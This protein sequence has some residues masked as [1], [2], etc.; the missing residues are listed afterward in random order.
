MWFGD[1][2]TL[3]WWNDLWLNETFATY[4]SAVALERATEYQDIWK[5]FFSGTKQMAYYEDQLVTSHPISGEVKDTAQAFT[6]FDGISYGKGASVMKQLA[7]YIGE[8][9]F[10]D[11]IRRYLKAHAFG[12]AERK[13]FIAALEEVRP[14]NLTGWSTEWLETAGVNTLEA[15]HQCIDKKITDFQLVQTA[16]PEL[17]TL[18][19][20]RTL[21][22][23]YYKD[24]K[25][26]LAKKTEIAQAYSGPTTS[27]PDAVG[28]PCPDFIHL[29]Q[30][31]HD[32]VRVKLDTQSLEAAK[33]S[34]S[35][36]EDP[37]TRRMVWRGLWDLVRDA[38][39][40][41][42]DY[43][44]VIVKNLSKETDERSVQTV[45]ST[46]G[47][48]L[49]YAPGGQS[50]LRADLL[51]KIEKFLWRQFQV[52]RGGT[53][54]QKFYW[55]TLSDLGTL[56]ETVA[57]FADIAEGGTA[58]PGLKLDLDRRWRLIRQIGTAD[59]PIGE[60]LRL[61]EL[62][63][64]KSNTGALLAIS[65]EVAQ[66][67]Y[68]VKEQWFRE[69]TAEPRKIRLAEARA[70]MS[71][72]FRRDQEK[73]R[74]HFSEKYFSK[75]LKLSEHP[76][77]D[78]LAGYVGMMVPTLCEENSVKQLG[79]FIDRNSLPFV[80]SNELKKKKQELERCIRVRSFAVQKAN[81]AQQ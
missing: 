57:R 81:Q 42:Q 3:R 38:Q 32:Y 59:P 56:P 76:D 46:L 6:T 55:D 51:E 43:L 61:T 54:L 48:V 22:G 28:K 69:L 66:P 79:S 19:S 12:N 15:H 68:E 72:F 73:F 14:N 58:A 80:A 27:V 33:T 16:T 63:K 2:V 62:T 7:F 5:S 8:D 37:L 4:L 74:R 17:P 35:K 29:N 75:L 52:A 26:G 47:S 60:P 34:L 30:G 10:R 78:F 21:I 11:G 39:L 41:L 18:R 25:G 9:T 65:A 20:H 49:E 77:Q 67:L 13:D 45:L 31:D 44:D 53:D 40:P 24:H 1:L 70:A 71:S 36:I 23:L 50:G 64:D